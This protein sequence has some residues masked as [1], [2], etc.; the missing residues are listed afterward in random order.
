MVSYY[1]AE[2]QTYNEHT[3]LTDVTVSAVYIKVY[4]L[5]KY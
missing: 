3:A 5:N 4:F 1:T 2:V